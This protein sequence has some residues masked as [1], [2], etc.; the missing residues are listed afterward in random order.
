MWL[1]KLQTSIVDS[2][3]RPESKYVQLA[4]TNNQNQPEV[5]TV[6]FRGFLNTTTSLLIHTDIRSNKINQIQTH[7]QAQICW[8]FSQS[9]EQYRLTGNIQIIDFQNEQHQ[10]L[11]LQHW[12]NLSSSAQQ[13]YSWETPGEILGLDDIHQAQ[14][15]DNV[16][17]DEVSVNFALLLFSVS[18]V[19]HLQLKLTPHK[20][21][22][23]IYSNH[24]WQTLK[25]NP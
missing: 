23:Y 5:R 14:V 17:Q 15:S 12:Q 1:K 7:N 9:R 4:T 8:Y 24:A 3:T 13:S 16:N 18:E 21:N 11:R 2:Q 19:D 10:S 6:V 22:R 20:R 25:I